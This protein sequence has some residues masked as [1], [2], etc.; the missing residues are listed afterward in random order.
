V[1][2]CHGLGKPKPNEPVVSNFDL[3]AA[4]K[5]YFDKTRTPSITAIG[6]GIDTSKAG[7]GGVAGALIKSIEFI[8]A[9]DADVYT[10]AGWPIDHPLHK[11][12]GASVLTK[13]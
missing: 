13:Y 9:A 5:R 3:D 1:P 11:M 2:R 10:R 6:L 4:F 12:S 7:N 8:G